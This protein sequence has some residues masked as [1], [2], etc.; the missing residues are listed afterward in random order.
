MVLAGQAGLPLPSVPWL[1]AAGAL[2][3]VGELNLVAAIAVTVLACLI[4]DSAWFYI[5]RRNGK[6]VLNWLGRM[7]L[8]P[9]GARR[10]EG[11]LARHAAA[12]LLGAKFLGWLGMVIPPLAGTIGMSFRRFL[13][14]DGVGSL[15]YSSSGILFGFIF[16]KQLHQGMAVLSRLRVGAS[17]FVLILILGYIAFK[18]FRWSRGKTKPQTK[19]NE[20]QQWE[21]QPIP[22]EQALVGESTYF[23]ETANRFREAREIEIRG[24]PSLKAKPA[25]TEALASASVP[26]LQHSTCH[27]L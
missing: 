7:S 8:E 26:L 20:F 6:R 23:V 3:A 11:F 9:T 1:L 10:S 13:I 18:V 27:T 15:L 12:G 22:Q 2:A 4:S 17:R 25:S 5:G 16:S 19:R 24:I 14:F 21:I